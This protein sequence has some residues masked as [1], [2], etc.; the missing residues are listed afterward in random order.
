[1]LLALLMLTTLR[2]SWSVINSIE[3]LFDFQNSCKPFFSVVFCAPFAIYHKFHNSHIDAGVCGAAVAIFFINFYLYLNRVMHKWR[4][5]L[6]VNMTNFTKFD[7]QH[8]ASTSSHKKNCSIFVRKSSEIIP[9]SYE[10]HVC[11][12]MYYIV[13]NS[14]LRWTLLRRYYY[15]DSIRFLSFAITTISVVRINSLSLLTFRYATQ[16]T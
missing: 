9:A 16:I 5:L 7:F 11:I 13:V 8:V 6:S 12:T 2:Y 15:F 4:S 1:M 10:H 14:V 3:F